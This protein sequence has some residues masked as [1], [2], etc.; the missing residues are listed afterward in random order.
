MK[1]T[2]INKS[3]ITFDTTDVS[4]KEE[5]IAWAKDRGNCHLTIEVDADNDDYLDYKI[6]DNKAH[7][8][9]V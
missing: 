8:V 4:S 6:I 2:L 5:A 1:A 9:V 3:G 7:H